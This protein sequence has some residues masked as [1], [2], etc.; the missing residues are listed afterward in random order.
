MSIPRQEA[1]L[2]LALLL[3]VGVTAVG[4]R[5][6]R[7]RKHGISIRMQV[8]LALATTA[9]LL[10]AA[11]SVVV[12]DRLVARASV[13]AHRAARDDA[14]V[15]AQLA[16]RS[17][18]LLGTSLAQGAET[19]EA[20]RALFGFTKTAGDTRVQILDAGGRC[21]FDT[22][23]PE[24]GARADLAGR[25]EVQA[26][27]AGQVDLV[28][29][30]VDRTTVAA[31]VPVHS[32]EAIV[33]AVRVLK[34]TFGMA[35]IMSDVAPKVALLALLI[36]GAAAL[37]GVFIGRGVA[38]PIER[39]TRA[40]ERVAAG[41]RQAALPIPRGREVRALTRAFE[42]MRTE[43]EE[44][45]TFDAL[46]ADLSHELKNPVAS[47]VATAEVLQD[48]VGDD[49]Q[50]AHRFASRIAESASRLDSL[51]SDLLALARLEARGPEQERHPLDLARLVREA[52]LRSEVHAGPRD[53]RVD[54]AVP[55]E[56][57]VRGDGPWLA[58]ALD[59]L[60]ANAVA[61]APEGSAVGVSVAPD[62]ARGAWRVLVT[63]RG[64]GVDPSV[65][66]RVFERFVT[67][68]HGQGGTGLGLAIVRAVTEAHGGDAGLEPGDGTCFWVTLPRA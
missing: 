54:L 23:T 18:E 27:L 37:A 3:L 59:N 13:F 33:G 47:L 55:E 49:E 10:T 39:L 19:L 61:H 51:I 21:L 35:E 7:S 17:M 14:Q 60:L 45:H 56:A 6:L 25:P 63:D 4:L 15:V 36:G 30:H 2:A 50:A 44:R 65:R 68:R 57:P 46:A 24:R 67:T 29:R 31:A 16:G 66:D 22:L 20:S 34:T 40:A 53:V 1:L 62:P 8:F 42:S 28:A 11:F 9:G 48:A 52:C 26:A 58:R 41:E 43:L 64:P 38:A 12:V 5:L 32:G